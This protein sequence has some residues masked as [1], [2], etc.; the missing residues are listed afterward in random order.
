MAVATRTTLM[1][2]CMAAM[3]P[4]PLLAQVE[5]EEQSPLSVVSG[6]VIDH[7]TGQPVVNAE[8]SMS[9]RQTGAAQRAARL[10]AAD[11]TFRFDD[12]EPGT[13]VFSVSALGYAATEDVV[14][15]AA[16]SDVRVVVSLTASAIELQPLLVETSRRPAFMD[17]F[18]QRR[19]AA[20]RHTGFFTSEEIMALH[21]K[22]VTD[23]FRNV[24]GATLAPRMVGA[25][26][27]LVEGNIAASR[28]CVPNLFINGFIAGDSMPYSD[29]YEPEDIAAVELYTLAH[30]VPQQFQVSRSGQDMYFP[31]GALVIWLKSG[32]EANLPATWKRL[33]GGGIA[34]AGAV[35]LLLLVR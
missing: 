4:V 11:G 35:L 12:V 15:V 20:N 23:I 18:E 1:L 31:C 22:D 6:L 13:Y 8:V 25:D 28:R 17:G 34:A 2:A 5:R 19:A 32:A 3:L 27:L 16:Q 33:L 10:S 29:I 26:T 9:L 21:P 7:A 24:P 30:D 14:E